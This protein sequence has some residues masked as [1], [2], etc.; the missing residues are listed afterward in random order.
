MVERL[1]RTPAPEFGEHYVGYLLRLARRNGLLGIAPLLEH[2][3]LRGKTPA[4]VVYHWL[5]GEMALDEL[6]AATGYGLER[7]LGMLAFSVPTDAERP[8]D[9]QWGV[10]H[11]RRDAPR[12]CPHCLAEAAFIRALW[13]L[14]PL[15]YCAQHR[16]VLIDYCP[17][18]RARLSW[19]RPGPVE[20][21]CGADWRKAPT[22]PL[23]PETIDLLRR[24]GL[25]FTARQPATMPDLD[26]A[27]IDALSGTVARMY[28]PDDVMLATPALNRL[29]NHLLHA[30]YLQAAR[31]HCDPDARACWDRKQHARH[32]QRFPVLSCHIDPTE[33]RPRSPC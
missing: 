29:P 12:L 14:T 25:V 30:I 21:V 22:Q 9:R 23:A 26:P 1:L 17:V 8:Y 5:N 6:S 3:G 10:N 7:L 27:Q 16:C 15:T 20:C 19:R 4:F 18:C 33:A 31:L 11:F 2:L 32:R 28:R 13:D 24:A